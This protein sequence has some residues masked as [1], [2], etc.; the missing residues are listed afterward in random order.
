MVTQSLS[1]LGV[2][3][4]PMKAARHENSMHSNLMVLLRKE[5]GAVGARALV[6]HFCAA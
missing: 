6:Q 4:S 5:L 2:R 1:R 3:Y